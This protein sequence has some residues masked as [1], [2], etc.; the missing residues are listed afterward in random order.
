MVIDFRKICGEVSLRYMPTEKMNEVSACIR[1]NSCSLSVDLTES[2]H[3]DLD[4]RLMS[5]WSLYVGTGYGGHNWTE[6]D[7]SRVKLW[8]FRSLER[9]ECWP[10]A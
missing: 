1:K 2:G 6:L 3:M 8:P 5:E 9:G 7:H 10:A 4:A